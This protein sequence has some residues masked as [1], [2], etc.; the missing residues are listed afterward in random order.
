M[1][2]M[3]EETNDPYL[4]L[5]EVAGEA[6]LTW[7]RERNADTYARIARG[8][9]FESLRAEIRAVLDS[10]DRIPYPVRRGDHLYNFW[11]DADHPRGLWRRTT[12]D[13]YRSSDPQWQVLLDVDA[14]GAQES[15]NWVWQGAAVLRPDFRRCLVQ[16]SRGGA[17]ANV[18]RE[19]DLDSRSFVADG[20]TLPEAKS[21]VSWIDADRI[22]VGTDFGPDSL[23]SSG[24]P[25]IIKEWRRGTPLTEA[26]TVFEG[27]PDDVAVHAYHDPTEGY[28][29]DF[30]SRRIGFYTGETYLR[31]PDGE[32]VRIDVPLDAEVGVHRAFLVVRTRTPWTVG[33][34]T[35][36]AGALLGALFDDFVAGKRE[37]T[38]L[39][40]PDAHTSLSDYAW[41][42]NHLIVNTLSDVKS[43]LEVLTPGDEGWSRTPLTGVP[44][45]VHTEIHATDSHDSDEFFLNS[46]GFT[47][48]AT[49]RIGHVGGVVETVKQA[50]TFFDAA[51]IGVRQLFATSDDG[52]RVPY[53]VIGPDDTENTESGPRPTL[54]Y[55]YGGFEIALTPSYS[56]VMGR[57]WLARG[58]TYVIA[59][60]RGGGEYGP[61]WHHAALRERRPRA[62]E[63]FAA[64]ATDLVRRGI[65][66]PERLGI[67]GGSN[68]GLLMGVMLTRYPELFGAVVCQVPLLDMK[69]Y[70]KMLAGASWMAEFGDPDD[71][72]DWEFLG[73]YSPYHQVAADRAY[74]PVLFATST[75][76]DR[77]HPG[78][79]R[80]MVARLRQLG[81]DPSYYENIEGGHGGAADNEQ[82][83]FKNAL[84]LEFL[85]SRLGT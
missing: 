8:E 48:P 40:E 26:R 28:E 42:R 56:G 81:Y 18:V 64:V 29:R 5:E 66:T 61:D 84:A 4:W 74:P 58:G 15:E 19:F 70:H 71:D 3:S 72:A 38:V 65:T 39:F 46:S 75:R 11:Q 21:R 51:G 45:L 23:T 83:A 44:D 49:L 73:A 80:K 14:L 22:Y 77:V 62:Y 30:V 6:P 76:D 20:F 33:S 55:G 60:I 53:F 59:N 9:R 34:T 24:Y 35:Y 7:V 79:A 63:D 52:T 32:L 85:W 17:D 1:A 25:R 13:S 12:L 16:L 69:R 57:G 67:Q 41:T 50:P 31:T 43:R 47:E 68:G 36:P 10:D 27:K 78:H 54:L 37:L 2:G 82:L